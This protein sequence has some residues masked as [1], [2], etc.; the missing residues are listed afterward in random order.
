LAV[1]A[2]V[3]AKALPLLELMQE[4]EERDPDLF[5]H[6]EAVARSCEAVAW[7]L[8]ISDEVA[9]ALGLAGRLHDLGKAGI[10]REVLAKVTSLTAEDWAELRRH[11]AIGANLLLA[12]ELEAL[13]HWILAHHERPDGRGYPYGLSGQDIPLPARILAAA[14]SYDAMR[15]DRVY[16]PALSHEVAAEELAQGIGRQFDG[17]V[18]AALL[19]VV[20]SGLLGAARS[21]A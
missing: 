4:V 9:S 18:V 2:P 17:E 7:R 5:G 20:E 13:A 8:G 16:R 1:D 10:D 14:D 11:P 15:T 19:E 6:G 21:A 12:C 3:A